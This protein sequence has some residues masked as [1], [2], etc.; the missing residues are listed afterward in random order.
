MRTKHGESSQWRLNSTA[1]LV[2]QIAKTH[3]ITYILLPVINRAQ[4]SGAQI[5]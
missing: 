5:T 4:T 2:N 1:N 3:V